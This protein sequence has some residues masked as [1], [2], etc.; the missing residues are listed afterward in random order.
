MAYCAALATWRVRLRS[1]RDMLMRD[2]SIL[3][4]FQLEAAQTCDVVRSFA[5]LSTVHLAVADVNVEA[6]VSVQGFFLPHSKQ[7][8][9]S[10]AQVLHS[11]FT[12]VYYMSFWLFP[13]KRSDPFQPL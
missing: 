4:P 5:S 2:L 9:F 11:G 1:K 6:Y 3:Q 12:C 13:C 8:Y 7:A 10:L